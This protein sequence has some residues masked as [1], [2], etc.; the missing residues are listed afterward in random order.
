MILSSPSETVNGVMQW[1]NSLFN[2]RLPVLPLKDWPAA[3]T[4]WWKMLVHEPL[5]DAEDPLPWRIEIEGNMEGLLPEGNTLEVKACIL[6]GPYPW[7]SPGGL[8]SGP[9]D[10]STNF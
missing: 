8:T 3:M 2:L 9:I 1:L 4:K 6:V 5:P 10:Q 7:G